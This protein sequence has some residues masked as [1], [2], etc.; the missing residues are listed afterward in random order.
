MRANCTMLAGHGVLSALEDVIGI[1]LPELGGKDAAMW[2][3][4]MRVIVICDFWR[5]EVKL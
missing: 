3:H 4:L 5:E 2:I 1:Q